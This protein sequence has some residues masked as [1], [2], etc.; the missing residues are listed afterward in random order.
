M[1]YSHIDFQGNWPELL[2][3]EVED[4]IRQY[5]P[6][7]DDEAPSDERAAGDHSDRKR[8]ARPAPWIAQYN[9]AP[10]GPL[11]AIGRPGRDG[12]EGVGPVLTD[13]GGDLIDKL[14]T[15]LKRLGRHAE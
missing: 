14:R 15:M 2:R 5:D 1:K 3:A 11:Y 6:R 4:L 12:Q 10:T 13:S 9:S 8:F 7:A